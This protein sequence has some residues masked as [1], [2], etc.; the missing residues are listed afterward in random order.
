M[1]LVKSLIQTLAVAGIVVFAGMTGVSSS[2]MAMMT[3]D[4]ETPANEGVCDGLKG[5]TPGLYGLCVAYCE[6]QDLDTIDKEPPSEKILANYEKKRQAG[7]PDMPCIQ[8]PECSCVSNAELSAMTADGMGSCNRLITNKLTIT[9]NG[10][11]N[12][13]DINTTPGREACRFVDTET[14]PIT[15]RSQ[16]LADDADSTAAQ[17]AEVC[18]AAIDAA[19][20]AIG[21]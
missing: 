10:P 12:F 14:S 6:A 1:K 11:L 13:A 19:C 8:K 4:G 16:R 9:D 2:A 15:V 21:Q 7:D 20:L 5:A 18:R 17:K 3:P